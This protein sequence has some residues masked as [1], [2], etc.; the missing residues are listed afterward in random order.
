MAANKRTS[1]KRSSS[2]RGK[3]TSG[4]RGF[5]NRHPENEIPDGMW[6]EVGL[7]LLLGA[8]VV[9]V[10][11][12]FGLTSVFGDTVNSFFFG[13]FGFMEYF[14]PFVLFF[15]TVF[16]LG[17]REN[18]RALL[19]LGASVVLFVLCGMFAQLFASEEFGEGGYSSIYD[20]A[21]STR[22][23]GG[24]I[25]GSL[26]EWLSKAIGVVGAVAVMLIIAIIC[27]VILTGKSFIELMKSGGRRMA[28]RAERSTEE[29]RKDREAAREERE[30][31]RAERSRER[32]ERRQREREEHLRE[33]EERA[34]RRERVPDLTVGEGRK[35]SNKLTPIA[36]ETEE[37]SFLKD[38]EE[39][40]TNAEPEET[41]KGY[42]PFAM[43]PSNR[44]KPEIHEK[45]EVA[46]PV[47]QDNVSEM[48]ETVP[49]DNDVKEES[50]EDFFDNGLNTF[51]V[52]MPRKHDE[53]FEEPETEPEDEYD[54]DIH[55]RAYD[56]H[57]DYED[58]EYDEEDRFEAVEEDEAEEEEP[59]N[60]YH[61]PRRELRHDM[62]EIMPD[63][64]DDYYSDTYH[65]EPEDEVGEPDDTDDIGYGENVVRYT[66]EVIKKS[67]K[68]SVAP[69]ESNDPRDGII[70]IP[71]YDHPKAVYDE[72]IIRPDLTD[73]EREMA[74]FSKSEDKKLQGGPESLNADDKKMSP[75][76]A[77]AP[78]K[79]KLPPKPYVFPGIEL[80]K[81]GKPA[82]TES[83]QDLEDTA[84]KLVSTLASF[85]V[86]VKML[87]A[88]QG[89]SVTRYEM[90]PEQG[91]KVNRILSLS[92]DIQLNLAATDI[93]IE[94]PIPGKAAIGIEIPNKTNETV[95]FRDLIEKD[96]FKTA[97][98]R[99]SFAV[100]KNI[101]GEVVVFDIAKMPHLLIA[102]ATGSGKSV[103]INTIIMSILYKA[104]PDEVKL[105]MIDP[106]VVELSVYNGL[107]HLLT[108][109]VTDPQKAAGALKWGVAE[110]T[111]RYQ[112]F[113][114]VHV[115]NM[116]GYNEMVPELNR[117]GETRADGSPYEIMPQIVIIVDELADLMMV[118]KS[119]VENAICRLAQ[120]AR[121]A[122]IHLIIATQRPSVDVITGLIKANMPSRIAFAVSSGVDSRTILDMVGAEKLLG[123]GDMLFYPQ[124]Y[125]KPERIQGAFITDDEVQNVVNFITE[126]NSNDPEEQEKIT[127]AIEAESARSEDN[128]QKSSADDDTEDDRDQYFADAGRFI[129]EK[130]KA[131]IGMLQRKLKIG[132]NRAARI[133]DQLADANV[134]TGEDGTKARQ[135]LMT[136]MQFENYLNGGSPSV[137]IDDT[138][139]S[140][141]QG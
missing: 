58:D 130:N 59:A 24:V 110:M 17:N 96:V 98:S 85:N 140:E 135:I 28:D 124:G 27:I 44:V 87:N 94:A 46:V 34:A 113:A 49:E 6:E 126:E 72:E 120:L 99:L 62:H 88:V 12:N 108:P 125:S 47:E 38:L 2:S 139:D 37:V 122:G 76:T 20:F 119:D 93:R 35:K 121:A 61:I 43:N 66:D 56:V 75:D 39:T 106:K 131:S 41:A 21:V 79:K 54:N 78:E 23:G 29:W 117:K 112:L 9:L 26:Y 116:Q 141:D 100:G 138:S 36:G 80:L 114:R 33:V 84:H 13:L 1:S 15:G 60:V 16:Y 55:E 95:M 81:K 101:G 50:D 136:A 107:P 83:R 48:A 82:Q 42:S 134:V 19:R 132:F 91:V 127:A 8:S 102:G 97:K 104:K 67:A 63:D 118:A 71:A 137:P 111:R 92:D 69:I 4:R 30:I 77:P 129:I 65:D 10:L 109:V 86:R 133:M 40:D 70:E 31:I 52:I 7:L 22:K 45:E 123:K 115:R 68:R 5:Q 3:R 105:I 74:G 51:K 32:S 64:D 90:Q 128:S 25:F 18:V 89:P 103:C 14:W 53:M 73:E 11:G 57:S